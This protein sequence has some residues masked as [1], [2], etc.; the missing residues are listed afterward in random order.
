MWT[1][2]RFMQWVDFVA[3]VSW[4]TNIKS[5]APLVA[6]HSPSLNHSDCVL[7][8]KVMHMWNITHWIIGVVIIKSECI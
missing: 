2:L 8:S 5:R 4:S 1:A 6:Y 7:D 3:I